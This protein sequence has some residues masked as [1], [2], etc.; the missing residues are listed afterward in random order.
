MRL[1]ISHV[2]LRMVV[3][4]IGAGD[5]DLR[6]VRLEHV[7]LLL[8][9]LVRHGAHAAV[10]AHRRGH[11]EAETGVARR[12]LDEGRAGAENARLLGPADHVPGHPVLDRAGR[13]VVLELD[14]H[15]R[16]A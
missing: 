2:A 13:V 10:A 5:D 14:Q 12:A 7:D 16:H 4:Q 9:H 1:A 6:A 11:R 8:A 15:S 3:R